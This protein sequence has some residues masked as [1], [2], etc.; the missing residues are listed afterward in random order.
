MVMSDGKM[1]FSAE[2]RRDIIEYSKQQMAEGQSQHS[3]A[4]ELGVNGWTLN[5]WH[6]KE[7]RKGGE[8]GFVE[9]SAKKA[10]PR[11]V[12][13]AAVTGPAAPFEVVCPSGFEVRVPNDFEATRLRQLLA[14][15][16]GS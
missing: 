9:V 13:V 6:Q 4:R 3:V 8:V 15:L 11:R 10:K 7:R 14:V 5:R 12:T 1:Q 16:E 2:L